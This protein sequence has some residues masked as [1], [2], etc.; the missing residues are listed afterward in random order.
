MRHCIEHR[1][2]F[3]QAKA[4]IY[5]VFPNLNEAPSIEA[6]KAGVNELSRQYGWFGVLEAVRE[7]GAFRIHGSNLTD[8][9][10][11]ERAELWKALAWLSYTKAQNKV[12][13]NII[14]NSNQ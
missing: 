14:S 7:G 12:S 10:C 8:Q 3:A 4:E 13:N 9:Q 2:F 5:R 1:F 11:A 6:L